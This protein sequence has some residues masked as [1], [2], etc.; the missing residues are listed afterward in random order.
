[1]FGL[2][3]KVYFQDGFN[4]FDFV[5]VMLSIVELFQSSESSGLSV[6]RAFRL[7]RIFKIIRSWKQLRILLTTVLSSLTA[8]TN[9][10]FL[11]ILY[12]FIFALLAK[13]FYGSG[14]LLDED[15]EETRY[16]F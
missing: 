5:I 12:L 10:G 9:L 6:L 14:P 15:G 11:T 1:M 7:L 8:I 3:C 13:Q 2:G 4:I 16:N